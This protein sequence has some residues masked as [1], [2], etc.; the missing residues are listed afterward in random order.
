MKISKDLPHFK[1]KKVLIIIAGKEVMR[2]M[3]AH[4]DEIDE[5]E[6]HRVRGFFYPDRQGYIQS[7]GKNRT[8]I[9][10]GPFDAGHDTWK[11]REFLLEF[12]EHLKD[13]LSH[14]KPDEIYLFVEKEEINKIKNEIPKREVDKI[15]MALPENYIR[16][17]PFEILMK[18]KSEELKKDSSPL[19]IR[20]EPR[21]ILIISEKAKG[22]RNRYN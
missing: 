3:V 6:L 17:H 21:Q 19:P 9:N 12:R 1:N 10:W 8:L 20:P 22:A 14:D 5:K 11:E 18:I 2:F 4:D 7:R 16:K 15:K 13:H